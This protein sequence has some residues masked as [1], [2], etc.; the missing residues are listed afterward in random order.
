[1]PVVAGGYPSIED[2]ANLVRVYVNDTFKGA[3]GTAGEGRIFTDGA[4]FVIPILNAALSDYQRDLDNSGVPT[5]TNEVIFYNLP[6][7]NSAANGVGVPNPAV[8]QSLTYT[9]FFD[10]Y[11]NYNTFLLPSDLI[12]PKRIWQRTTG[13]N[14]TF[15][16][17]QPAA[18]GLRSMYQNFGIGEWEWRMDGLF[19][20]GATIGKDIR[21]RYTKQV[22]FYGNTLSPSVFPTTPLPFRESV[23]C[24][25]YLGAEK[26]CSSRLPPGGTA[27]LLARYRT[28]MDKV[29]NR[30]IKD[31]QT[32]KY[33][34]LAYG[35]GGADWGGFTE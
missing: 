18:S 6:P 35:D 12:A 32:R 7:I 13:T 10:G 30:Q 21:L 9:G 20:N 28:E 19:W 31:M 2:W 34:R 33:A 26:F 23:E 4:P 11:L 8:Q 3:T 22:A 16:L 1:M 14:L 15:T 25:A 29:I 5:L 27:D 24:L 17:V